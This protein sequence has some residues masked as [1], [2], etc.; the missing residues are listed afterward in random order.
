MQSSSLPT[1]S[2]WYLARVE[3]LVTDVNDNAPEWTM[4][5]SPYLAVVSPEAPAGTL[6]YKLHARDGDEGS[7]GEV[8]YFLSDGQYF[9]LYNPCSL[10]QIFYVFFPI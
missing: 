9:L 8:E 7:N 6:V 5:P 1:G 2:D 10:L 3:L 4:V